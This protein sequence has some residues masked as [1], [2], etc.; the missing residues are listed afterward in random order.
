MPQLELDAIGLYTPLERAK[1]ADAAGQAAALKGA[2]S[3][4]HTHA[5]EAAGQETPLEMAERAAHTH[6]EGAPHVQKGAPPP[7]APAKASESRAHVV[8]D[9]HAH[10]KQARPLSECCSPIWLCLHTCMLSGSRQRA[11]LR[12]LRTICLLCPAL[13]LA[14]L[15]SA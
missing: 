14:C 3:A 11:Q 8:I 12:R 5:L 9:E 13:S 4:S 6:E 1:Q 7:G 10:H 2:A 15:R